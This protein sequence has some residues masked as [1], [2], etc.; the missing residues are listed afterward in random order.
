MGV[1]L[2]NNL[3]LLIVNHFTTISAVIEEMYKERN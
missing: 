2:F 3:L 1:R